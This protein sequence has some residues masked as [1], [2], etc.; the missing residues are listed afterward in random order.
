MASTSS[1]MLGTP[2]T[3]VSLQ[4][5]KLSIQHIR[6]QEGSIIKLLQPLS[7]NNWITWHECMLRLAAV[8]EIDQ[9]LLGKVTRP[10]ISTDSIGYSNW[11]YNDSNAC[12]L[13]S[14]NVD[15]SPLI[16]I[17]RKPTSYD[18]W[19]SLL[20]VYETKSHQTIVAVIRNLLH[21]TATD[22]DNIL[23]HVITLK[24]YWECINLMDDDNFKILDIFFKV[25]SKKNISGTKNIPEG[26]QR[27]LLVKQ[28]LLVTI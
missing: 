23:N 26:L 14:V 12:Y 7:E 13:L 16:Y 8:C 19:Q 2:S 25:F 20:D 9:Y 15:E 17:E 22:Q 5:P 18:M 1:A 4:N 24:K 28:M 11:A 27:N 3:P 10:D 6:M 21:S